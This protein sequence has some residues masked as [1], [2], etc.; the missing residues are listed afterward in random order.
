MKSK[1]VETIEI[2]DSPKPTM[3]T[4][5]P[6][7]TPYASV[8]QKARRAGLMRV[9]AHR[10]PMILQH[11]P[12]LPGHC[13]HQCVLRAASKKTAMRAIMTLRTTV[14]QELEQA[15]TRDECIAGIR[16]R[17]LIAK[18]GLTLQTHL[19]ALRTHLWTSKVELEIATSLLAIFIWHNEKARDWRSWVWVP[20]GQRSR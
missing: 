7:A 4:S 2:P 18:K 20:Q 13:G 19:R 9:K 11:N 14:A 17:D 16:V 12:A 10:S 15:R 3:M 8:R 1:V 6:T 5:S